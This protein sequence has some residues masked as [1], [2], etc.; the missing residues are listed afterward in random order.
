MSEIDF[1]MI[2][3]DEIAERWVSDF[4]LDGNN[5]EE[6]SVQITDPD[7]EDGEA[8]LDVKNIIFTINYNG[9]PLQLW[10]FYDIENQ[11]LHECEDISNYVDDPEDL[12]R[13]IYSINERWKSSHKS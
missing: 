5:Y 13:T 12:G 3:D 1:E 7:N 8:N 11:E 6:I 2:W 10:V 4:V 9:R